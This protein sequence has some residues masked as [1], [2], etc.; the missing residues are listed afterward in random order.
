MQ[1]HLAKVISIQT[2]A[3]TDRNIATVRFP[4]INVEND[5]YSLL[6]MIFGKYC[7]AVTGK[8][9]PVPVPENS[10]LRPCLRITGIREKLGVFKGPLVMTIFKPALGLF[11][12]DHS[13]ILRAVAGAGL[14]LIKDDEI[15][16]WEIW[17]LL[18]R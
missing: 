2:E 7:M 6:T 14:D 5:I 17:I 1:S 10:G 15:R 18:P 8:V 3:G 13:D 4:E 16:L 12:Q 11:P 9:V